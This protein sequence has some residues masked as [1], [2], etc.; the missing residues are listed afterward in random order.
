MKKRVVVIAG[1]LLVAM[2][3]LLLQNCASPSP[4]PAVSPTVSTPTQAEV[5]PIILKLPTPWAPSDK[6]RPS[7]LTAWGNQVEQK[8]GGKLKLQ[9]YWSESFGKEAESLALTRTGAAEL[10]QVAP[11]RTPA[12]LSLWLYAHILPFTYTDAMKLVEQAWKIYESVPALRQQLEAQNQT[13]LWLGPAS[14]FHIMTRNTP[15]NKLEDLRGLKI[16]QIG[17]SSAQWLQA[18]GAIPVTIPTGEVYDALQ[19]GVFD[20]RM[21]MYSHVTQFG[22]QG[23]I[24]YFIDSS[25]TTLVA[26]IYTINLDVWKKLEP[27]LQKLMLDT[28]RQAESATWDVLVAEDAAAIKVMEDKGVNISKL[29]EIERTKLREHPQVKDLAD[30][31]VKE[32]QDKGLPG[33]QVM[34]LY[35]QGIK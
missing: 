4:T 5:K 12:E 3:A 26:P 14:S 28:G 1:M 35:M 22:W 7:V 13:L 15:I 33:R 32:M 24:K 20:G 10:G 25:I 21:S 9:I 2:V 29:P 34:D 23:L 6:G 16:G 18:V 8:S 17:G 31:W 19:K 27:S 11:I 30:K